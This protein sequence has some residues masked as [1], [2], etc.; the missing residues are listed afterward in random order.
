MSGRFPDRGIYAIT[1]CR[2]LAPD[3]LLARTRLLLDGGLAA[4]QYRDKDWQGDSDCARALRALCRESGTLFL[5]NDSLELARMV[6]ADGVHLGAGDACPAQARALLGAGAIIGV[7]CYD[8]RER[9]VRAAAEGADYVSLGAFYPTSSKQPVRRARLALLS[10]A[11][12]VTS[13]PIVA[14]GGITPDNGGRLLA[15]GADVLAVLAGLYQARR[16]EA[17]LRKYQRL[18]PAQVRT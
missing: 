13:L 1:D 17:A 15:A 18:F 10:A 3:A 8:D 14:V 5:I 7:S 12:R 16:P 9:V 11:R 2:R 6:A 4:L